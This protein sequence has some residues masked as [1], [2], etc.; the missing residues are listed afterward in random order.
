MDRSRVLSMKKEKIID[1]FFFGGYNTEYK[2]TSVLV[3]EEECRKIIELKLCDGQ[4]MQQEGKAFS[5]IRQPEI[6]S[7]WWRTKTYTI[8]NCEVSPIT[9]KKDCLECPTFSPWGFLTNDDNTTKLIVQHRKIIWNKPALTAEQTCRIKK[10]PAR[11]WID[12][13]RQ[14]SIM[15]IGRFDGAVRV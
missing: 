7:A 15:E 14:R 4:S 1:S 13:H 2:T 11:Y 12:H 6:E 8:L 3:T 5:F 9:L 10:S